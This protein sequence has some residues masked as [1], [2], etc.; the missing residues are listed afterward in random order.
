MFSF[1]GF[2]LNEFFTKEERPYSKVTEKGLDLYFELAGSNR[3][4][5][6]LDVDGQVLSISVKGS[7]VIRDVNFKQKLKISDKY[8]LNKLD[9]VLKDGILTLSIP[10]QEGKVNKKQIQIK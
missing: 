4:D 5:I 2:D 9:A 7:T 6:E 3:S 10:L 1:Y 8:D